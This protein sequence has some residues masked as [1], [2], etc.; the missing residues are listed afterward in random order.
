MIVLTNSPARKLQIV[1]GAAHTTTAPRV[2]A[3]WVDHTTTTYTPDAA[4]VASNGTT[5]TDVVAAPGAS[6]QRQI[7][8]VLCRNVDTVP[9]VITFL[10]DD[11]GTDTQLFSATVPA[12]YAVEYTDGRGWSLRSDTGAEVMASTS[13]VARSG[14]GAR[15]IGG[16]GLE[17]WYYANCAN[18]TALTTGAP[19]ANVLRALPFI[20]PERRARLDRIAVN[21][22]TLLAGNLRVGLYRNTSPG[23]QNLYPGALLAD[24]GDI[25]SGT[26]GVKS[27][28]ISQDLDPGEIY[29]LAHVGSVAATLRCLAVG[30]VGPLLGVSSA[31]GTASSAGVSVAHTFG[32]L[33]STF[34]AGGAE[35]TAVPIPALAMRFSA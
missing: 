19:T 4:T 15:H 34:T 8:S 22:T 35:I 12:G 11:A 13:L 17:R 2:Y 10:L 9:H 29:W 31:L 33:P 28:T 24:S 14:F 16:S 26:A 20:A 23:G 27:Y 30:G 18:A 7:K 21:V 1:L 5:Q 32:A 3:A 25:S 6:T